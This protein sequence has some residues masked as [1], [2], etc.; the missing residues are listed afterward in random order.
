MTTPILGNPHIEISFFSILSSYFLQ[1]IRII[2]QEIPA[3]PFHLIFPGVPSG[4]DTFPRKK[5][6]QHT[7]SPL[8]AYVQDQDQED[9]EGL[10]DCDLPTLWGPRATEVVKSGEIHQIF[11]GNDEGVR[12]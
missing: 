12:K 10:G 7:T 3:L 8:P 4:D 2:L 6:A 9:Q 11:V 1:N 5:P